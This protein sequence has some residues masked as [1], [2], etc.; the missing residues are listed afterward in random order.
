MVRT[1]IQLTDEQARRVKAVAARKRVSQA[2]VIRTLVDKMLPLEEEADAVAVRGRA[3]AAAGKIR[4]GT[5]DLA[6]KHDE[7]TRRGLRELSTY[8][9]TSAFLTILDAD[10]PNHEIARR[11]WTDLV[12][13]EEALIT[14]NYVVVET[15]AL[16]HRRVGL[17]A[18]R[19][20]Q[21]DI[22]AVINVEWVDKPAHDS[23]MG[24]HLSGSRRGPSLVDCIGFEIIRSRSVSSVLAYDKHF[25]NRG[26][27]LI[28]Q[29]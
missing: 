21:D 1:Q 15:A 26:F 20:L 13:C 16:L 5:G 22:L 7:V 11:V 25:R 23:A 4:S 9:D 19:W 12:E 28:G 27:T 10:D 14:S 24:A 18:V 3:I 8:I 6:A 17:E 2:E 29:P